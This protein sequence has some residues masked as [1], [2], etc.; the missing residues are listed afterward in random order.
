MSN[1]GAVCNNIGVLE[2]EYSEIPWGDP[3][4]ERVRPDSFPT[5][6]PSPEP[7]RSAYPG[8]VD[9]LKGLWR[10]HLVALYGY[11]SS[12]NG[13]SSTSLVDFIVVVDRTDSFHH[14][15]RVRRP[16]DYDPVMGYAPLQSWLNKFSPNFYPSQISIEGVTKGIK[17][18]TVGLE[19]FF[20]QAR[21]GMR[22]RDGVSHLYTAGRLQKAMLV[23]FII[24]PD[25]YTQ[26]NID[27]AINQARIDGVWLTMALLP[28]YFTYQELLHEYV[29]LSY[30]ADKRI[31][32]RNKVNLLISQSKNEYALMMAGLIGAFERQGILEQTDPGEFRKRVSLAEVEV[33]KW[34]K[35]CAWYSFRV[36][37][38]K[39]G[40]TYGPFNG[41]SYGIAKI[42]RAT[43]R[44]VDVVEPE[45]EGI[46]FPE[47][48]S[49]E[50]AIATAEDLVSM[51]PI[52]SW[53]FH[54]PKEDR[55]FMERCL[56]WILSEN[57][58]RARRILDQVEEGKL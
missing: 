53:V 31:E 28:E 56:H 15:N 10:D 26:R 13:E 55:L 22:G 37:Y 51:N 43:A 8:M 11:G 27:L 6:Y 38:F 48:P 45:Q 52:D 40:L 29:G 7:V 33:R 41:L 14:D 36:N 46:T 58:H 5:Y 3:V 12:V 20:T 1:Y 50:F 42:R 54:R 49:K 35:E 4:L 47:K 44:P 17:Y 23:P 34:L 16:Q 30:K 57:Y 9:S 32:K 19:D 24:N 25:S 39:N 2:T 21:A 18:A